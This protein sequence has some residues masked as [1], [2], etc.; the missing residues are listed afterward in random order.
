MLGA[1]DLT[2][3]VTA[4]LVC[5]IMPGPGLIYVLANGLGRGVGASI[6]AS[7][8]TTSGITVHLAAAIAGLAAVLHASA[9]VFTVVKLVGAA[10]LLFLAWQMVRDRN[11]FLPL[12]DAALPAAQARRIVFNGFA[13]NILNPKLSAF[14]LAFLP[15]F[16]AADAA[17]PTLTML[18]LGVAFMVMTLV[19]FL[20]C[21]LFA[22]RLRQFFLLRPRI[23]EAIRWAFASLF[24]G[25]GIRLALADRS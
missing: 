10:Y 4:S 15:Q 8:G 23:G 3:F 22:S 1:T 19:V 2:L 11:A 24:L 6:A 18:G 16:V 21:G 12:E 5:I 25:L 9:L 7:F 20:L 13:A 17:S 14:F